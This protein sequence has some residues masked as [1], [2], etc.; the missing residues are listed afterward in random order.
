M[1]IRVISLALGFAVVFSQPAN[2][3]FGSEC[4]KPKAS[5]EKYQ[6]LAEEFSLQA[7]KSKAANKAKLNKDLA[8]CRSDYKTFISTRDK[9][10]K[11]LIKSKNNCG[12]MAIFD[13]YLHTPGYAESSI[14][15]KN[16][17]QVV[18]NN[19]KCF[20]PEVVIEAQRAL[21]LIK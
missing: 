17:H 16:S 4:K 9:F 7:S 13:E 20:S 8:S 2:A 12:I 3:L 11:S 14:A 21:K 18:V 19:Q 5:Y 10:E 1:R 6:K 15:T